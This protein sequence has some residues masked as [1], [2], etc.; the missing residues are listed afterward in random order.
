MPKSI[1]TK[2]TK[3]FTISIY[4]GTMINTHLECVL[5]SLYLVSLVNLTEVK[6]NLFIPGKSKH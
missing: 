3:E 2:H 1:I 4:G 5:S 6:Y